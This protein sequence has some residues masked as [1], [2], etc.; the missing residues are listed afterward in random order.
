MADGRKNNGGKRPGSGRKR[1]AEEQLLIEKLSPMDDKVFRA[2]ERGIEENDFRFVKMF[3]EYRF[4]KPVEPTIDISKLNDDQVETLLERAIQK[5][6]D[7]E[8]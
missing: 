7:N 6:Q 4:G 5:M 1:K 3:F 8:K 2:I